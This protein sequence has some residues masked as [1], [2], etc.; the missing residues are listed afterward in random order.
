MVEVGLRWFRIVYDGLRWLKTS[1]DGSKFQP[2]EAVSKHHTPQI[3][4][5]MHVL[6]LGQNKIPDL[7]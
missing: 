2:Q 5:N 3:E 7:S 4:S 6:K 1:L